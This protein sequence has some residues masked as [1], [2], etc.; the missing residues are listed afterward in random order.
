MKKKKVLGEMR[1]DG[2]KLSIYSQGA[3][4]GTLKHNFDHSFAAWSDQNVEPHQP[5]LEPL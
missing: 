1:R 5:S 2:G 4:V 3:E